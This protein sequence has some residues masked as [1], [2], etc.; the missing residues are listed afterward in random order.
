M[1]LSIVNVGDDAHSKGSLEMGIKSADW[2]TQR[3]SALGVPLTASK[4]DS[5]RQ[6]SL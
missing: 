6:C 4:S 2:P 1:V 5:M 3:M